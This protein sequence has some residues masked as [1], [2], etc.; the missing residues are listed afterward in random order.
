[1]YL[2]DFPGI[3]KEPNFP[4]VEKMTIVMITM[5]MAKITTILDFLGIQKE[6]DFPHVEKY[7]LI[8]VGSTHIPRRP[9]FIVCLCAM[10]CIK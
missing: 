5:M 8:S 6:P 7:L 10:Y 9:Y 4:Q 1:M 2:M 3:E